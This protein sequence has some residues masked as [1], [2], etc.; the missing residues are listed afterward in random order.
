MV[1]RQLGCDSEQVNCLIPVDLELSVH[2]A[3]TND[4]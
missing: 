3:S 4:L 1:Y 2:L